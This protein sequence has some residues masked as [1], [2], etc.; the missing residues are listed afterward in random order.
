M[1][2][3]RLIIACG[4]ARMDGLTCRMAQIE[5]SLGVLRVARSADPR[6]IAE[7]NVQFG[8]ADTLAEGGDVPGEVLARYNALKLAYAGLL[9]SER[10]YY[11]ADR[12]VRMS[13]IAQDC[14]RVADMQ[15]F[16]REYVDM[17]RQAV[18]TIAANM[19][20][21][22]ACIDGALREMEAHKARVRQSM[23]WWRVLACVS[24]LL[25]A[26]AVYKVLVS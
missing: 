24:L 11:G 6:Q 12:A 19:A 1:C 8:I 25:G 23:R 18:D 17:Q 26:G 2:D 14:T 22:E 13:K 3:G 16:V 5:E 7:M 10:L 21:S 4:A 9:G 20:G 15:G